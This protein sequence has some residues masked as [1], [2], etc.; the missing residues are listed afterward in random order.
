MF[1]LTLHLNGPVSVPNNYSSTSVAFIQ[2]TGAWECL[3]VKI[4][5]AMPDL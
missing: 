1:M 5:H 3:S 4:V 2:T